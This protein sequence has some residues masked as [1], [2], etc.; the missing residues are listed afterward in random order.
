MLAASQ[1]YYAAEVILLPLPPCKY[2]DVRSCDS[3]QHNT[4]LEKTFNVV[5]VYDSTKLDGRN[6]NRRFSE[7]CIV[8]LFSKRYFKLKNK[9]YLKDR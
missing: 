6:L 4:A 1:N 7:C 3:K 8:S 9:F 5:A 2:Q